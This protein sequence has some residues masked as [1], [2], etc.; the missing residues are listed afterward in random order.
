MYLLSEKLWNMIV[1]FRSHISLHFLF[2]FNI[3]FFNYSF[4]HLFFLLLFLVSS[5][6]PSGNCILINFIQFD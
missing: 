5:F 1:H 4:L 3:R 2:L 6:F